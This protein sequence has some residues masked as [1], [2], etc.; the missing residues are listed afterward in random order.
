[1]I[2]LSCCVCVV[3]AWAGGLQGWLEVSLTWRNLLNMML[4]IVQHRRYA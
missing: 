1:M 2:C 3:D 4:K